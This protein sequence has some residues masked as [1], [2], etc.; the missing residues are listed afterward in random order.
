MFKIINKL[1][2]YYIKI[3]KNEIHF[4]NTDK[5]SMVS[6]QYNHK[7]KTFYATLTI[8]GLSKPIIKKVSELYT[9]DWLSNINSEDAAR[10]AFLTYIENTG[11]LDIYKSYPNRKTRITPNTM[12]LM[13]MFIASLVVSNITGFKIM[14]LSFFDNI[15]YIPVALIFF[16]LTY[17]FDNTIT[18]I[19]GYAISRVIIWGG[20]CAS[21]FVTLALHLSIY[22]PPAEFWPYQEQYSLIFSNPIRIMLASFVAYFVG[23]FLNSYIISKMKVLTNGKHYALRLISSTSVGALFDSIIFCN[24]AF[25]G[26]YETNIVLQ[27]IL[28]QYIFKVGYEFLALPIT[29]FVTGY[30]KH[31]DR[32]DYYD[33]ETNYNPFSISCNSAPT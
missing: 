32:I 16:P 22:L 30:L 9:K 12:L 21:L 20:L 8:N 24:M 10:I 2:N 15:Y 23:E 28:F 6:E 11:N 18:E 29:Y 19:Y 7:D 5:Y 27:M 1:L 14:S 31:T 25:Y 26:L 4:R 13:A 33:I 3:V 17:I